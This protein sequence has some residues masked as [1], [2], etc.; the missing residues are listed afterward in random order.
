MNLLNSKI[1][2]LN[3]VATILL[4]SSCKKDNLD[5]E[6]YEAHLLLTKSVSFPLSEYNSF[7]TVDLGLVPY[8]ST[9]FY[10]RDQNQNN[11]IFYDLATQEKIRELRIPQSGK[12]GIGN[13][14]GHL[15]LSP[16]SIIVFQRPAIINLV[17]QNFDRLERT[18]ADIPLFDSRY[19]IYNP[20]LVSFSKP[21]IGNKKIILPLVPIPQLFERMGYDLKVTE[22]PILGRLDIS[23]NGEIENLPIYYPE[24]I[25][26]VY[27]GSPNST[28]FLTQGHDGYVMGFYFDPIIYHLNSNF[29]I[30][31]KVN[32]ESNYPINFEKLTNITSESELREMNATTYGYFQMLYDPYRKVYYRQVRHPVKDHQEGVNYRSTAEVSRPFSVMIFDENFNKIGEVDI[33]NGELYYFQ[34]WFV[35]PEGLYISTNNLNNPEMSE[36][37]LSFDI[38]ELEELIQD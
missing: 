31:R 38:F 7:I 6:R 14:T 5:L 11:I 18:I 22:I 34:A 16:D 8:D 4:F 21:I 35:G 15:L 2:W 9:Q 28:F 36:D 32:I 27:F 26:K 33:P 25:E 1:W 29:E 24:S 23:G 17:N 30:V 10:F 20:L 37:W 12:N 13:P 19:A 3:I